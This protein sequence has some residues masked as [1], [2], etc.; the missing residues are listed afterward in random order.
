MWCKINTDEW[1]NERQEIEGIEVILLTMY[2]E[3]NFYL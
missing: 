3:I 1:K 2:S